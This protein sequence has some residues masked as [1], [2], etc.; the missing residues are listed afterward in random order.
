MDWAAVPGAP[1]REMELYPPAGEDWTLHSFEHSPAQV[2]AVWE[3]KRRPHVMSEVYSH[4]AGSDDSTIAPSPV[5][6][7][8]DIPKP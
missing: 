3:R 5:K 7:V 4:P 1:A 2:I 8:A 6:T